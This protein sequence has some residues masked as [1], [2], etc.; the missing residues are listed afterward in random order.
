MQLP[1]DIFITK[2]LAFHVPA[3]RKMVTTEAVAQDSEMEATF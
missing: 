2:L 3:G 1:D